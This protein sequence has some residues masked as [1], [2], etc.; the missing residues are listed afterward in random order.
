MRVEG[1]A[2]CTSALFTDALGYAPDDV[3]RWL[4]AGEV[5]VLDVRDAREWAAGHIAGAVWIPFAELEERLDELDEGTAWV[6]VCPVG[7]ISDLAADML[8]DAGLQATNMRGGLL[9]WSR[10]RLPLE[11]GPG[12]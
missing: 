5:G 1:C 12:T 11:Q 7:Q 4:D 3:K 6:C 2:T 10:L 9:A 8:Q